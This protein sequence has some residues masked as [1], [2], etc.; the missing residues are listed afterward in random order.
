MAI[1][2]SRR[3]ILLPTSGNSRM[4]GSLVDRGVLRDRGCAFSSFAGCRWNRSL[5]RLESADAE[6]TA[7]GVD[8]IRN[9]SGNVRQAHPTSLLLNSRVASATTACPS[10]DE[11]LA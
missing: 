10:L 8:R 3:F 7:V 1:P 2:L 4:R 5:R 9:W 6:E 11:A